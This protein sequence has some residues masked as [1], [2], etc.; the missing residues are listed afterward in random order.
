MTYK[1]I[2]KNEKDNK[3]A[4]IT[5]YI[6]KADMMKSAIHSTNCRTEMISPSWR[7][8]ESNDKEEIS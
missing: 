3:Y 5:S 6:Q 1:Q 7:W 2:W 4:N 8:S